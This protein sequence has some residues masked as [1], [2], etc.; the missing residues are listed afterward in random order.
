MASRAMLLRTTALLVVVGLGWR[1]YDIGKGRDELSF[2]LLGGAVVFSLGLGVL[3][4]AG[5]CI[6]RLAPRD[7]RPSGAVL[8]SAAIV[9]GIAAWPVQQSWDDGCNDHDGMIVLAGVPYVAVA[10]PESII[11]PYSHSST[12]VDC[13]PFPGVSGLR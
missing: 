11:P 4:A 12:L 10:R 1:L 7:V 13:G 6:S 8:A 9:A 2:F 5:S 3:V